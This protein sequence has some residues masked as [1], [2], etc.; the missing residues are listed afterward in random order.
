M[1]LISLMHPLGN[2]LTAKDK[3][4]SKEDLPM[5][6]IFPKLTDLESLIL[7]KPGKMWLLVYCKMKYIAL[8]FKSFC[9][10]QKLSL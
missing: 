3:Q 9:E 10:R 5:V 2:F 7:T 4:K 6:G 8:F 1:I